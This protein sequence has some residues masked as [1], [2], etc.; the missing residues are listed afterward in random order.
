MSYFYKGVVSKSASKTSK[1]TNTMQQE[2]TNYLIIKDVK[3]T[4]Q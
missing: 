3:Q 2:N 4:F 1:S